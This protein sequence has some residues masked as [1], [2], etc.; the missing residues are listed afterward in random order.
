[1]QSNVW[2]W[3]SEMKKKTLKMKTRSA[4]NNDTLISNVC[5]YRYQL[6]TNY[7]ANAEIIGVHVH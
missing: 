7:T 3:E 2:A 5:N 4:L 6:D 1:M